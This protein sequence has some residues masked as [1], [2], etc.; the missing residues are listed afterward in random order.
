MIGQASETERRIRTNIEKQKD[1][2]TSETRRDEKKM[3][4][5]KKRK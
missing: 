2:E 1:G 4:R 5:E 3:R